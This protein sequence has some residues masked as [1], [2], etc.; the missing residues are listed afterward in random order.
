MSINKNGKKILLQG[1]T[2][3]AGEGTVKDGEEVTRFF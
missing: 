1:S 3:R 2:T